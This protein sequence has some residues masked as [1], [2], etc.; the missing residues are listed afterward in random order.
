M[1]RHPPF[2]LNNLTNLQR[3]KDARVHCAILNQQPTHNPHLPSTKHRNRGRYEEPGHAWK[4]RKTTTGITP[5][6]L[7]F[8]D[9][10]GC[11]SPGLSAAP[12]PVPSNPQ[13]GVLSV[14][15]VADPD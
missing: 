9:P 7:F 1:P 13:V 5:A 6:R 12:T 8:Q 14:P 10:T 4:F 15:A 11:Q 2:A 3:N